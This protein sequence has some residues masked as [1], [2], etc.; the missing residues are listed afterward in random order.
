L[1]IVDAVSV[2]RL[3]QSGRIS[4]PAHGRPGRVALYCAVTAAVLAGVCM[5][6]ATHL[7]EAIQRTT[8]RAAPVD[9][10][11][12]EMI[13]ARGAA[14]VVVERSLYRANKI[15]MEKESTMRR[16]GAPVPG[17]PAYGLN[18]RER[19]RRASVRVSEAQSA[20]DAREMFRCQ[21]LAQEALELDPSNKLAWNVLIR[22]RRSRSPAPAVPTR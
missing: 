14:A 17:H 13:R 1:G 4:P 2:G 21:Q 6:A 22:A 12:S 7:P 5:L 15:R 20:C 16:T 9:V 18:A 11:K 3:I 8:K 19:A 10:A